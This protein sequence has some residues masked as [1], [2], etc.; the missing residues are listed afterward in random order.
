MAFSHVLGLVMSTILLTVLWIVGFGGYAIA[1]SIARLR[2]RVPVA[3]Y[4]QV[5]IPQRREDLLRQ[6]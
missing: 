2:A 6:F 3:S 5:A 1:M 4:W